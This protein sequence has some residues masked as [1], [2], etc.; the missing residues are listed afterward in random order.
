MIGLL[1]IHDTLNFG[2]VLQTYSLYKAVEALGCEIQLIDYQ[3][4][5]ITKRETTLPM[6][7]VRSPKDFVK[8][9]VLHGNLQK[10]QNNFH[11]FMADHMKLTSRYTRETIPQTNALFDRFLVGSD[12]VWGFNI[13]GKD[14]TYMLD[15]VKDAKRYAFSASVG[16]K[17]E[18]EDESMIQTY[19]GKFEEISVREADAAQW[20]SDLLGRKI[21]AT[22]DPTMLWDEQFWRKEAQQMVGPMKDKGYKPYVLVYMSDPENV[23]IRRAIAYGKKHHLPVIYINYRAPVLGTVDKRPVSLEEWINLMINADTVFSASYHGM[24]FALYFHKPFFYF[25]WVNQSRMNSLAHTLGIEHREGNDVNLEK[26][27]PMDYSYIDQQI[28]EIRKNSWNILKG[29]V[30]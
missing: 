1:T 7:E 25:N 30:E 12:I 17:W 19:L 21:K 28:D 9:L 2:S 15:F 18:K 4:E 5:A 27:F 14:Y 13:T 6:R 16:T 20:V 26:D 8:S 3:C 29:M 11:R 23:C 22:C 10:R 24:L